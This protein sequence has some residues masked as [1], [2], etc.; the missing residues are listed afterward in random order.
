MFVSLF[1]I[2]TPFSSALAPAGLAIKETAMPSRISVVSFPLVLGLLPFLPSPSSAQ[3]QPSVTWGGEIRPRLESRRNGNVPRHQTISMRTR[4]M[5]DARLPSGFHLFFQPQDVRMWGEEGNER[6]MVADAVDVHQA[7]FEVEDL[8]AFGGRLRVGRQ[9]VALEEERFIG[10][11]DWGQAGQTFDGVRW[12]RPLG[13][14]RLELLLIKLKEAQAPVHDHEEEL[15]ALWFTKKLGRW[16]S[17]DLVALHD[18]ST[19][20]AR[21]SQ[22]TVG[23]LWKGSLAPLSFRAHVMGQF[24]ERDGKNVRASF[25]ALQGTV[26]VAGGKGA[27]TLWYDR[28]SGDETPGDAETRTFTALYGAR[29]R[30]YGNADYFT[31]IPRDTGGLGLQDAALKLAFRASSTFSLNL[32]LHAFRSAAKGGRDSRRFGEEADLQLR[33]RFRQAMDIRAGYC[34]TQLGPLLEALRG[35][36]GTGHFGYLM[37]SV[38]F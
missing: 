16:G 5:L 25:L 35:L 1:P 29:N 2:P 3:S 11:P 37:T 18:R 34:L 27:V 31:E 21:T 14:D 28:L 24:G 19:A 20:A 15:V 8:P 13:E 32:D 6:D 36:E 22:Y 17:G 30:Y 12:F 7:Y 38:K 9:E 10:A 4:L 33:Y 26:E 23:G